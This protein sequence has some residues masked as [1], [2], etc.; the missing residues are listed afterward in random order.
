MNDDT[1]VTCPYNKAH[2]ALKSRFQI[3]LTKCRENHKGQ[4]GQKQCPYDANH[5]V[6]AVEFEYHLGE[7]ESRLSV[8]HFQSQDQEV[9]L[10]VP[11]ATRPLMIVPAQSEEDWETEAA[12]GSCYQPGENL[13]DLPVFI[14]PTGLAPAERKN[15]RRNERS[16][17]QYIENKGNTWKVERVWRNKET[18]LENLMR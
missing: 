15:F 6:N 12:G 11:P 8:L 16:R 18:E 10:N 9:K 4:G 7:C 3:H 17:H 2:R 13:A 1:W 14:Q 5:I